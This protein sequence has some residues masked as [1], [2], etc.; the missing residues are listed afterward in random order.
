MAT[1]NIFFP[2]M[3]FEIG[4]HTILKVFLNPIKRLL[5]CVS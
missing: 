4:L 2:N 3:C 5:F 1:A